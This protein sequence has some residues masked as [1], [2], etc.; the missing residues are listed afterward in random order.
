MPCLSFVYHSLNDCFLLLC[1]LA[2]LYVTA[3]ASVL[4]KALQ[5]RNCSSKLFVFSTLAA[6]I[7]LTKNTLFCCTCAQRDAHYHFFITGSRIRGAL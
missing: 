4:K 6:H 2:L 1:T 5:V 7:A 3:A